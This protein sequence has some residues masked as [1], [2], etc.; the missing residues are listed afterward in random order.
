M[1]IQNF[2][3]ITVKL[4]TKKETLEKISLFTG[5]PTGFFHIVSLNPENIVISTKNEVF[6]NILSEG[7][8]QLI[9]GVG[10]SL[11]MRF[12]SVP[13][14]ERLTGTDLMEEIIKTYSTRRLRV[15]FLGGKPDLA[16]KLSNC[17]NEKYKDLRSKGVFG[18]QNISN[19][20]KLEEK[21]I[22]SIVA[23]YKPQIIFAAFGS[24]HQEMWFYRHQEKLKGILCMGV[25]GGFDY[26][27]GAVPRAHLWIR[28]LG[29]E[30]LYRLMIQPWRFKRQLQLLTFIYL[31]LQEKFFFKNKN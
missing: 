30:W 17:Y 9:D 26:A 8:I 29:L 31:V 2:L 12:L 11:G 21:R 19:P 15:L 16:N 20:S 13:T 18:I 7:D 24:P 25:G 6:R 10:A 1:K 5:K 27:Y 28:R 3:G 4:M 23:D 22:F 14:V